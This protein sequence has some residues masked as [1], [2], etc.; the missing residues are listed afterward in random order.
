MKGLLV[1]IPGDTVIHRLDP[2]TKLI[3]PLMICV[4]CFLTNSPWVLIGI[5][6][7][8]LM[9]GV[10][11]GITRH[12]V[13]LLKGLAK[14][15][16]FLFVLQMLFLQQGETLL[17][18]PLGLR[19]TREGLRTALMGVLRLVDITLPLALMIALTQ[20]S[21]LTNAMVYHWHLPYKY[22]FAITSAIRFIPVFSSDMQAIMEAQTAR[23]V[24]FDTKNFFVKLK[25]MI[26][27]CV[28]LLLS[29]VKKTESSAVAVEL[30]GFSLR[31]R[32]S[33]WKVSRFTAADAAAFLIGAAVIAICAV[34]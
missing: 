26:P 34:M 23:G 5:L 6:V 7:L 2:R 1:Y 20:M 8:D 10:L 18:L 25:L 3:L 33:C 4:G 9:I 15:A 12:A 16:L 32:E 30:R 21:D 14:L 11:G 19:I 17:Q 28:P 22:A 27:L 24:A 31:R 13:R 29:S